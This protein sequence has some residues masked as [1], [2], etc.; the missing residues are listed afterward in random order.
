[1]CNDCGQEVLAQAD[2]EKL[3]IKAHRHGRLHVLVLPFDK[4]GRLML[5]RQKR[6][7]GYTGGRPPARARG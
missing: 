7:A 1:M 4:D 6:P 5:Q 3:V 2:D